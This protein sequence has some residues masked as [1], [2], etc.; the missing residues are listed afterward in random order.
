MMNELLIL[1]KFEKKALPPLKG[2]NLDN[3]QKSVFKN[4]HL[5]LGLEDN[6]F[7][8]SPSFHILNPNT[9]KA[10][11]EELISSSI[12]ILEWIK[13]YLVENLII[14][15]AILENNSYFIEQNSFLVIAR[16]GSREKENKFEVKFYSHHPEELSS[17]YKD[18]LYIGRDFID[19]FEFERPHF[20]ISDS[21]ES[22]RTQLN[23]LYEKANE[24]LE[25][26]NNYDDFF[27]EL[28]ELVDE[29]TE[30]ARKILP[31][32]PEFLDIEQTEIKKLNEIQV[33]YR[34]LQ[35]LL[36]EIRDELSE[37]EN[38]LRFEEESQF[39]KYVTK[40]KKDISNLI[41]FLNLKI[42]SRI[43]LKINFS[44]KISN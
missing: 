7:L 29:L 33:R 43:T 8:L 15:T 19:L 2:I 17:Y 13:H 6:L 34:S 42:I 26:K 30:R 1:Q 18:K 5:E 3:F 39:V 35:H 37:F 21:I 44:G 9:V 28:D 27:Q 36:I 4:L 25:E 40:Y 16:L 31:S 14:N 38:L 32:I 23:I 10:K 22:L 11:A 24:K 41:L 20:G 12:D